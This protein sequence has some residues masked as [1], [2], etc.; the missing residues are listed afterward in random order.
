MDDGGLSANLKRLACPRCRKRYDEADL[1]FIGATSGGRELHLRCLRC[2]LRVRL[3]LPAARRRQAGAKSA[4]TAATKAPG[5]GSREPISE[6]D[7]LLVRRFLA[8]FGGN[9]EQLLQQLA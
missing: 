2:R 5:P 1:L 9:L 8:D 4:R 6:Q 7:V 3:T